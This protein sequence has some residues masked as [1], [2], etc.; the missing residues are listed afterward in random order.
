MIDTIVS[1]LDGRSLR[2]PKQF[3]RHLSKSVEIGV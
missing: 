2:M 3:N 1:S